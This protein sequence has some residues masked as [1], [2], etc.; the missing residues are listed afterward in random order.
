MYCGYSPPYTPLMYAIDLGPDSPGVFHD[1]T[2]PQRLVQEPN[3]LNGLG[4]SS[5][6]NGGAEFGPIGGVHANQGTPSRVLNRDPFSRPP[7]DEL[8][9]GAHTA[10]YLYARATKVGGDLRFFST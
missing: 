7:Q 8:Q 5:G 1:N 2:F 10:S 3:A 6:L 4:G 9:Q